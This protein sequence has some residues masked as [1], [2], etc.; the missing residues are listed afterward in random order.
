MVIY[1]FQS[2]PTYTCPKEEQIAALA[3]LLQLLVILFLKT[4]DG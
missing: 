3:F 2:V 4:L 1:L